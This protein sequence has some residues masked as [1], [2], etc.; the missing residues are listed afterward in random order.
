M[1]RIR[2]RRNKDK[3]SLGVDLV[4]E[5]GNARYF[6]LNEDTQGL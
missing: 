3:E 1:D 4:A 5:H 2:K 6:T